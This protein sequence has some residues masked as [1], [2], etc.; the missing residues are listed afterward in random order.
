[1][2][3]IYCGNNAMN[4][5]LL[6]GELVVGTRYGC[7]KKGVGKGLSLPY[8]SNFDG[9]FVPI[10]T[11]RIYCGNTNEIPDGYSSLGSLPQCLQKGI[12]IGKKKKAEL[13][14]PKS[15]KHFFFLFIFLLLSV[16]LFLAL[17]IIKPSFITDKRKNIILGQFLAY[18]ILAVI[19]IGIVV[20]L[21]YKYST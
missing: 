6:S 7:M 15:L 4:P 21:L 5:K 1:M 14:P 18:Y 2:S 10:D 11:R 20:F 17:Y 12:G 13:G 8:D 3:R 9:Q 19:V 16:S